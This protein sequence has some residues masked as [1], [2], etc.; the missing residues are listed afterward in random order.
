[1][2]KILAKGDGRYDMTGNTGSRRYMAPEV[3]KDQEY[4][5]SVDVYSFGIL[6]WELC[7]AE[8]PFYGYGSGK[9]MQQVVLGGERPKMDSAHTAYWPNN[10]QWLMKKC[11]SQYSCVRPDF[12]SVKQVLKDILNGKHEIPT[13]HETVESAEERVSRVGCKRAGFFRASWT[14]NVS[15]SSV[16]AEPNFKEMAQPGK[17]R[18]TRSWGFGKR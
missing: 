12:A 16:S 18:R 2:K 6:M 10:L 5:E 13:E 4:N 9:H 14:R 15:T 17:N 7:S 8:K 1:M 11:W 3:A